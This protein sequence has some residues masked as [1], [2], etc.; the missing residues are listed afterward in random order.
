MIKVLN[1]LFGEIGV[2]NN[3]KFIVQKAVAILKTLADFIIHK[4][5]QV[6][7]VHREEEKKEG[8][9]MEEFKIGEVQDSSENVDMEEDV[10]VEN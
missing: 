9:G 2:T 1:D 5:K 3:N 4:K 8:G 10:D 6:K 7:N